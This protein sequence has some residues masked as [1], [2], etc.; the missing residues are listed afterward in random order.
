MICRMSDMQYV[1]YADM[2][3]MRICLICRYVWYAV[4]I[5]CSTYDMQYVWRQYVIYGYWE[6]CANLH[7][8]MGGKA[9]FYLYT[10]I[11]Y[12][13]C[14]VVHKG[15]TWSL[16]LLSTQCNPLKL[17]DLWRMHLIN[18]LNYV[19]KVFTLMEKDIIGHT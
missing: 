2:L 14:A 10:S 18:H 19:C 16:L 4:C 9:D 6:V 3:S 8:K 1:W 13:T 11:Q 7:A 15:S 17:T 5:I 12:H